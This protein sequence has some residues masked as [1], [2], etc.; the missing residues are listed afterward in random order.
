MKLLILKFKE[1]IFEGYIDFIN[2]PGYNGSFHILKN[3]AKL[4]SILVHGYIR[5]N[6]KEYIKGKLYKNFNSNIMLKIKSG[7]VE[8][9][10]NVI[11]VL[12]D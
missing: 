7:L 8:V 10:S 11:I 1:I 4:F 9:D 3:H 6:I 2:L 5:F 12:I